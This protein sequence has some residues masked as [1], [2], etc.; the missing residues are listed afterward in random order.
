M[1]NILI[2][3][4]RLVVQMDNKR[5]KIA[6]G[7]IYIE[8]GEI[9]FVGTGMPEE[10]K[11]NNN[12]CEIIDASRCVALPGF[13]NTHH[14]LYQTLYRNIREVQDAE[15][16]DWLT[17]LYTVWRNVNPEAV[18]TSALVGLGE[19]LLT[20]CTT[21]TDQF[22]VFPKNQPGDLLDYE[23]K[24]AEELGIR[25]H[26]TRG[27]M[28]R[29]KSKGGLPPDDVVQ[30]EEEILK[31]CERVIKKYHN[32]DKFSMCRIA[33]SPCS[34]FSV[35]TGL[36]KDTVAMARKH[37]IRCHTHI[38][39]TLDEEKY[40]L[41]L[42]NMRPVAYMEKVGWLGDD[43]WFAHCI[44]LNDDEIKLMGMSKTGVAHCPVSN[45]RLGSGIAP[46]RKMIE[47]GVPVSLAV[48][49]AASNDSSNMMR[50]LKTCLLVHRIKSGISSMPAEDVLWMATRGGASVLGRNDIGSIEPGK[51]A[52]I[53]LYDIEKLGYAG[54][55]HDILASILFCGDSDI[56]ETSIVNGKIVVKN[57]RLN[58][59]DEH[60]LYMK[61]NKIAV[62]IAKSK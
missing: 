16:F 55:V 46:V 8:N 54:S 7:N 37:R 30:T 61:A 5:N 20:G 18:Y 13:V 31:D 14:H 51:A 41:E 23:I 15:L 26:P 9:K 35:T 53:V 57:G 22:Y 29:G 48:D 49:G 36:L 56:V 42:H 59:L 62:E 47:N 43:I 32:P 60:E 24:A 38:A 39:E 44:H 11:K 34:P 10:I 45:L 27:S 19:L 1:K 6:G 25:F 50:E 58:G 21:S 4:A 33:L 12:N 3:N 52:D 17:Y 2:K 40:C 28:S